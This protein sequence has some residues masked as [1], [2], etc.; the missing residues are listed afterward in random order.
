MAEE[1]KI[2]NKE[3][4]AKQDGFIEQKRRNAGKKQPPQQTWRANTQNKFANLENKGG[5]VGH[6]ATESNL[7]IRKKEMKQK[8]LIQRK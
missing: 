6:T 7:T 8:E 3:P 1:K 4:A 2:D 5:D